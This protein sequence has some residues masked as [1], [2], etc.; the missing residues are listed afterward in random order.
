MERY[1]KEQPVIIVKMHYKYGESYVETVRKVSSHA[2]AI[3]IGHRGRAIWHRATSFFGGLWNLVSMPTNHKQFLSSRRR[4]DVSLV[5]LSRNYA[6][7]SSRISSE[8]QECASRVVGDICRILCSTINRSVCTLYSNK[9]I[10]TFWINGAFYYKIK[11]RALVGTPYILES[12]WQIKI[13][14][15][16]RLRA[17]NMRKVPAVIFGTASF[18]FPF[19]IPKYKYELTKSEV[20][21]STELCTS[22]QQRYI[23]CALVMSHW[24]TM[25]IANALFFV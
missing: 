19:V 8:E 18:A 6:E 22:C 5:K 17:D 25:H 7:M 4:F 9:N 2:S 13:A 10:S 11:S 23:C 1:T 16:K 24:P 21:L 20:L 12:L 3:R 15:M 14:P